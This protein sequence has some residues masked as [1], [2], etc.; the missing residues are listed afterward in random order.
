MKLLLTA[1]ASLFLAFSTFAQGATVAPK[2]N[3]FMPKATLPATAPQLQRAVIVFAPGERASLK[4]QDTG[5][6]VFIGDQGYHAA[7]M[8]P[9]TA[10]IYDV[11][12][13]PSKDG[14]TPG[15]IVVHKENPGKPLEQFRLQII[16][17]YSNTRNPPTETQV[18]T[19]DGRH[20]LIYD[21]IVN[22][23]G[24]T[25]YRAVAIDYTTGREAYFLFSAYGQGLPLT[26][27]IYDFKLAAVESQEYLDVLIPAKPYSAT[28]PRS[29]AMWIRL[30]VTAW[31]D[32]CNPVDPMFAKTNYR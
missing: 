2:G 24:N 17:P 5:Y 1:V 32:G 19:V 3:P 27:G 15:L 30:G 10:G 13:Y 14:K 31:C 22:E 9:K 25:V 18:E 6:H 11:E 7:G 26:S 23:Q 8:G 28:H 12:V 21:V 20:L 4:N 16:S 29:S